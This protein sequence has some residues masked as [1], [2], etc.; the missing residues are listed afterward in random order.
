MHNLTGLWSGLYR[1]PRWRKP[2][3]FSASLEHSGDW[4]VGSTEE[5]VSNPPAGMTLTATLTGRV[6]GSEITFMKT[7]DRQ[8]GGYDAVSYS[9]SVDPQG[10]EIS[11]TWSIA[12]NWSGTFL[13]I[14]AS[15]Q[16]ETAKKKQVEK[17]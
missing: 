1:F 17:V 4:L 13:M 6:T 12:G 5:T 11:G 3:A 9:G 15:G 14:R 7:Y 8:I 10:M 2:V 16:A